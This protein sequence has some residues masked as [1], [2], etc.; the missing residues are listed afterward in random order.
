VLQNPPQSNVVISQGWTPK[1]NMEESG[2]EGSASAVRSGVYNS[3]FLAR[4]QRVE[5]QEGGVL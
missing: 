3:A 2:N 1:D 5:P 4:K